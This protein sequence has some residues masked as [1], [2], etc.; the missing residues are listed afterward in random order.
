MSALQSPLQPKRSV[1]EILHAV[2]SGLRISVFV[3]PAS[4]SNLR[5]KGRPW[6]R[7][8]GPA[9]KR[10]RNFAEADTNIPRVTPYNL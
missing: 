6:Q 9:T 4:D 7:T 10:L 5:R 2:F 1:G 8:F 3:L